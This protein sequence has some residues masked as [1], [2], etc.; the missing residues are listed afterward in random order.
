M[1]NELS[2]PGQGS[3]Q[4][5][6]CSLLD[7]NWKH[8]EHVTDIC[9]I[10][11]YSKVQDRHKPFNSS[12]TRNAHAA[13]QGALLVQTVV[14]LWRTQSHAHCSEQRCCSQLRR[15]QGWTSDQVPRQGMKG[16]SMAA[17]L[18]STPMMALSLADSNSSADSLVLLVLAASRA[19]SLTRLL[20]SAP[21]KPGVC[22]AKIAALTVESR[23]LSCTPGTCDSLQQ[24]SSSCDE[25]SR[26]CP[27]N[28]Q[29][30]H[31]YT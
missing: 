9:A 14:K 20:S 4:S 13:T 2:I 27:V 11:R 12:R 23:G 22:R 17:Y 24:R 30:T 26:G 15:S 18:R 5:L 1:E 19:A 16:V 21:L 8:T 31:V 7:S 6:R 25:C 29:E 3:G 28:Q 10:A